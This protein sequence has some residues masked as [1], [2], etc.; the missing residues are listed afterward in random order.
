MIPAP[1][2]KKGRERERER[3]Q[4]IA[5]S[6]VTNFES[7]RIADILSMEKSFPVAE[8]RVRQKCESNLNK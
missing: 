3:E 8:I 4:L 7:L 1:Q 6:R 5:M 2:K